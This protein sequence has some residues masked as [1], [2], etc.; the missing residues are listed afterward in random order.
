[1]CFF[2]KIE[3]FIN[4]KSMLEYIYLKNEI[5]KVISN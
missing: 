4:L 2:H 1:M 5:Y 3:I